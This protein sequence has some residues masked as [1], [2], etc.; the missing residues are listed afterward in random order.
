MGNKG[1]NIFDK[2]SQPQVEVEDVQAIIKQNEILQGRISLINKI[3]KSRSIENVLNEVLLFL[4][5]RWGFNM[6]GSQI[7]DD[8]EHKLKFLTL[9]STE[10]IDDSVYDLIT[11]D[12]P[13]ENEY[14]ISGAVALTQ[15]W[16]YADFEQTKNIEGLTEVDRES[17]KALGLEENL[18]LPVIDDGKTIGVLHLG[19][20]KNRINISKSDCKEIFDFVNNIASHI[21]IAKNKIEQEN[22]KNIQQH[23]LDLF[24]KLVRTIKLDEIL[25][26]L[27]KEIGALK[28]I[29]GYCINLFN[30][31]NNQLICNKISLSEEFQVMEKTYHQFIFPVEP[32]NEN[33]LALHEKQ[34]VDIDS[35]SL[36]VYSQITGARYLAWKM[37]HLVI[38]PITNF[39]DATSEVIGTIM[40]F[41]ETNRIG[42]ASIAAIKNKVFL[43]VDPINNSKKY[44]TFKQNEKLVDSVISERS[45]FLNFVNDVN[46][47]TSLNKIF[48]KLLTEFMNQY[49]FDLVSILLED[50]GV[51]QAR[52]CVT[53]KNKYEELP[54]I[55]M[56]LMKENP[57]TVNAADGV[58]SASFVSNQHYFFPNVPDLINLPMSKRDSKFLKVVNGA[59]SIL[60]VPIR[61]DGVPIGVLS[62]SSFD[63]HVEMSASDIDFMEIMVSFFGSA[64]TNAKMYSTVGQQKDEIEET[65]LKLEST[66]DKLVETERKRADAMHMAKNV[67]EAS[68]EAK[69]NFLANMS[70]EIRTPM[71]AII[72]L[73]YL[74]LRMDLKPKLED[75]L[76]KINYSSETLLGIVNDIL[77]FSKI[78]AGKL[79]IEKT[80]FSMVDIIDHISDI[81]A[82][83]I[84]DKQIHMLFKSDVDMPI[85][86]VG[87]PLRL[88]QVLI[89][90]ISNAVKFTEVG[91][92]Q[93]I[94]TT[95]EITDVN[96]TLQFNIIDTGIGI[97]EEIL[98][99]LFDSFAQADGSITR[100]FGGTG[101]GLSISKHLVELMGG[102]LKAKSSLKIGSDFS[103]V[104][105]FERPESGHLM[106]VSDVIQKIPEEIYGKRILVAT[107]NKHVEDFF[108]EV[109]NNH[110]FYVKTVSSGSEVIQ[111]ISKQ[112]EIFDI[113][114]IDANIP[115]NDGILAA[116][117]VNAIKNM[118][119]TKTMIMTAFSQEHGLSTKIINETDSFINKPIKISELINL[120]CMNL[121]S[122][123]DS[124]P[125]YELT[126]N[127]FPVYN[128][129]E[130]KQQVR[131]A[132]ILLTDDNV[133]N[134]QV[135][136]ELL[137]RVGISVDV[138]ANGQE[139]VNKVKEKRYDIVFMDLQMPIMGG[140]E[141]TKIIRDDEQTKSQIIIAMTANAMES[142]RIECISAGMN[143]YIAKPIKTEILYE[144]LL[145]W[146]TIPIAKVVSDAEILDEKHIEQLVKISNPRNLQADEITLP[147]N[148]KSINLEGALKMLAGNKNLL[149]TISK[150]FLKEYETN[151]GKIARHLQQQQF[152]E[153]QRL[154]HTIKGIAG[155]FSCDEFYQIAA[156]FESII[157]NKQVELIEDAF[158]D[159]KKAY[160]VF[161]NDVKLI[162]NSK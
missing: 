57:Y 152:F 124:K 82:S 136:T 42:D 156:E 80:D 113:V 79:D 93:I 161:L 130:V 98:P 64:I 122:T 37:K 55:W 7:V 40:I 153:A 85:N 96:I 58:Y 8:K 9:T 116:Q 126:A 29:D 87:D 54:K 119:G 143:D 133:I 6:L 34:V 155:T 140:T 74:A 46:N 154:I 66:Q 81:F 131:G 99:T 21:Q 72:G 48:K 35:S 139:A 53:N 150:D 28:G 111:L 109:L 147:D 30:Q 50:N 36:S 114:I 91:D 13:L 95:Q 4:K 158:E 103:F 145:K 104:I 60:H 63:E 132:S 18:I 77:D 39:D 120:I 27:G 157:K 86:V 94:I 22:L 65:L 106:Q 88:S 102:E 149:V 45:R 135:A 101:L 10:E 15:K 43:F 26:I 31:E 128:E 108:A 51:L 92:V 70:H 38:I 76:Q 49:P 159:Y 162:A 142:D 16:F 117:K 137:E 25:A 123:K 97:S 138:A 14:S 19:A 110:H 141:A 44:S 52:S 56:K 112:N 71:N 47:L 160:A 3:S 73:T 5:Q 20:I 2:E 78:E 105:K 69:S 67:A 33:Y 83:K 146:I 134:Q 151:I 84:A 68:A 144:Q 107:H 1:K 62:A 11:V 90:I 121:L 12:I 100:K 127:G 118:C 129:L 61:K 59:L 148:L 24:S 41:S 32:G 115:D 75:Y 89:N 23:T 17:I 125:I